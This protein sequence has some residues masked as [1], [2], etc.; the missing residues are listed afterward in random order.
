M[1]HI[2]ILILSLLVSLV[3]LPSWGEQ[4]YSDLVKDNDL[5]YTKHSDVPYTGK[6]KSYV[7]LMTGYIQDGLKEGTW[8]LYWEVGKLFALET[9]KKGYP[10]GPNKN[11][12]ENGQLKQSYTVKST[13]VDGLWDG[14]VQEGNYFYYYENGQLEETL[15]YKDGNLEGPRISY[16]ENGQVKVM[17]YFRKGIEVGVSEYFNEDGSLEKT[18]DTGFSR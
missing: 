14:Q 15:N 16:Y 12:Y 11:Y 5:Y 7:G 8:K 4:Y 9:F 18:H 17:Q 2:K 1:K 10:H 6:V 3:S 13:W